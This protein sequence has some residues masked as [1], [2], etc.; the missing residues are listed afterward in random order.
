MNW[1]SLFVKEETPEGGNAPQK[2]ATAPKSAP[3]SYNQSSNSFGTNTSGFNPNAPQTNFSMPAPQQQVTGYDE[4]FMNVIADALAKR[5]IP[6]PD[7]YEYEKALGF[8]RSKTVGQPDNQLALSAFAGL[9]AQGLTKERLIET[10][11]HYIEKIAEFEKSFGFEI[12]MMIKNDLGAKQKEIDTLTQKNAEIEAQMQKLADVKNKNA[13][14]IQ[15]LSIQVN[16][17]SQT[18]NMKRAR[19]GAAAK[20]YTENINQNLQNIEKFL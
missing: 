9:S 13:E 16:T 17:E 2:E 8:L 20:V 1:K 4:E 5:N 12:D 6:G 7:Y 19:F 3:S 18:L 11:R 10:A 14:Q 15:T